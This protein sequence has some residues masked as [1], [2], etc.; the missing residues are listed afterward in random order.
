MKR[1]LGGGLAVLALAVA[2]SAAFAAP[3]NDQGFY[4]K[5]GPS[6]GAGQSECSTAKEPLLPA[7]QAKK[8]C[9]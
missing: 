1:R 4:K 9:D 6:G 8:L 7:G 2:P 3:A 5:Q